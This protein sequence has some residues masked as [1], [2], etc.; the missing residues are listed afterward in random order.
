MRNV[1]VCT[2][3]LSAIDVIY[4]AKRR[5]SPVYLLDAV[6]EIG[7]ASVMDFGGAE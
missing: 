7:F 4:V 2:I 1:H 3:S 5:V 6:A